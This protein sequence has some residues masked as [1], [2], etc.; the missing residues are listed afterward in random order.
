MKL[1]PIIYTEAV[2]TAEESLEKGVFAY[3]KSGMYP[4]VILLSAS[5]FLQA[6]SAAKKEGLQYDPSS[7]MLGNKTFINKVEDQAANRA[8][9]GSVSF[10]EEANFEDLYKVDTSSG[11]ASFG[12]LAYQIGMYVV[13]PSWLMSDSSLKPASHRVWKTMFKLSE[14]GVYE[15]KFLGEYGI[16]LLYERYIGTERGK[17][18]KYI[19][20]LEDKVI[21]A[22]EVN[23][24]KWLKTVLPEEKPE[25]FGQFWAYR[26]LNHDPK[27]SELFEQGKQFVKQLQDTHNIPEGMAQELINRSANKFFNR[28]YGSAASD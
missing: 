6:I 20:S 18:M 7:N 23:F 11:V 28:L 2:R 8:V 22:D 26:K 27:I 1:Y 14:Q 21:P 25:N 16:D 10:H 3:L 12:P 24:L 19:Q 9:V 4:K 15:R 5:R 13:R 17:F